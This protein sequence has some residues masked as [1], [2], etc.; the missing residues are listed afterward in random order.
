MTVECIALYRFSVY[1]E[2][3]EAT[4]VHLVKLW[5]LVIKTLLALDY[6]FISCAFAAG[7]SDIKDTKS[8][9]D[10]RRKE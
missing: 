2:A 6:E 5:W 7:D 1:F 9:K 8:E 4:T 3:T 10:K